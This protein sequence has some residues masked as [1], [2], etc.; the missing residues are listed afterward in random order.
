[1]YTEDAIWETEAAARGDVL[2]FTAYLPVWQQ[3]PNRHVVQMPPRVQPST[4]VSYANLLNN[5]TNVLQLQKN[6][7]TNKHT[8]PN[9]TQTKQTENKKMKKGE[10]LWQEQPVAFETPLL[11]LISYFAKRFEVSEEK[12]LVLMSIIES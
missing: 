7:Q 1:M 3:P 2:G 4:V 8:P 6:R 10:I 11:Q 9:N 5:V 12:I